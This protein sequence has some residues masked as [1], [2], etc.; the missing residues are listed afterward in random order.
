MQN[1]NNNNKLWNLKFL[2]IGSRWRRLFHGKHKLIFNYKIKDGL[3]GKTKNPSDGAK[4]Q[5][6]KRT[7]YMGQY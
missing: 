3:K 2:Q 7:I 4:C 6:D 5:E 1:N